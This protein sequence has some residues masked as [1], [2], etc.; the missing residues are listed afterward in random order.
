MA[1]TAPSD[2][3]SVERRVPSV[4]VEVAAL[5]HVIAAGRTPTRWARGR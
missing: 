3:A 5:F 4:G 1:I 2:A